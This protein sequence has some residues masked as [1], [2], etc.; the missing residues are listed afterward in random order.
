MQH[1]FESAIYL[2]VALNFW[3]ALTMTG[4]SYIVSLAYNH[5]TNA[6]MEEF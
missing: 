3:L 6:G 4:I 5:S 1:L 2:K